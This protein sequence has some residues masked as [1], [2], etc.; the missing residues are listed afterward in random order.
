MRT[1]RVYV[2]VL[3]VLVSACL[4]L[5]GTLVAQRGS[6]QQASMGAVGITVFVEA[7]FHGA[8]ANFTGDMPDLRK[9][10]MNDRVDSIKIGHG[11]L[12]QVCEDINFK[13]RCQIFSGD[14]PDLN[15]VSWGGLIS[16]LRPVKEGGH[17]AFPPPPAPKPHVV[18]FDSI[19]FRGESLV[20]YE[21]IPALKGFV[22]RAG[23]VKVYG[24][25]WQICDALDFWGRCEMVT[26]SVS[27]LS[28]LGFRNKIS[29]VRMR[30]R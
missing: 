18:L 23:S 5:G 17:G 12:W 3:P 2:A 11:E 8:N 7:N 27:D 9:V 28:R 10:G 15:K 24:G 13:G 30:P 19:D 21:S 26:S 22:N 16:S 14:E 25:T 4:A 29:S 6:G 20:V 1:P